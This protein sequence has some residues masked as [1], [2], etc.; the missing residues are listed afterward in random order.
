MAKPGPKYVLTDEKKQAILAIL[1]VGC[2]R[3]VAARYVGCSDS[4]IA[5]TAARDPAFGEA[6]GKMM[7]Q[8]EVSLLKRIRDAAKKDKYWRAAAWTL[9]R[10]YPQRY[11]RRNP[12]VL[13]V[14]QIANLLERFAQIVVDEVPVARHRKNVLR[15]LTMMGQS[16]TGTAPVTVPSPVKLLTHEKTNESG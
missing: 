9:E 7:S 13:T 5:N 8:A 11:A 2:S 4:T 12:D 6:I 1:G 3:H 14:D 10:V 16:L 15:R